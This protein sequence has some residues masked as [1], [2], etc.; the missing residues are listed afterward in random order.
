MY[1]TRCS[2]NGYARCVAVATSARRAMFIDPTPSQSPSAR[3]AMFIAAK[4][5]GCALRQEGHV[6]SSEEWR[7]LCP[8]PGGP[9][10]QQRRVEVVMP[11]A[12]R[13]M[14]IAAK[15]GGCALRQEDHVYSSEEWRLSLR[16]EGH[17]YSSEEWRLCPPAGGPCQSNDLSMPWDI[18]RSTWPSCRRAI[19]SALGL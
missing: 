1:C 15:S 14:F 13:T 3:R 5:G 19:G 12:R 17:V 7:W 11:S 18:T 9:C 10:L 2:G 6:Y 16:Q 8:P 4:S